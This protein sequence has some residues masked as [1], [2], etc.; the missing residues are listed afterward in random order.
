MDPFI[1]RLGPLRGEFFGPTG[2]FREK[3]YYSYIIRAEASGEVLAE[4]CVGD[5]SE[6]IQT[7]DLYLDYFLRQKA[8]A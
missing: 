5:V 4:G 6:G 8:L 3:P 2:S 1:R 7:I